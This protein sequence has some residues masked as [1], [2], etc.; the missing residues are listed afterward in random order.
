[1]INFLVNNAPAVATIFF[2]IIFC[3]VVYTVFKK[4]AKSKF[5][6]YSSIPLNDKDTP[7]SV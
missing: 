5:K 7:G 4:G 3:Y 1:M 6:H 2:F